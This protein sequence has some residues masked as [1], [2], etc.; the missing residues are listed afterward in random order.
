MRLS[1]LP[2]ARRPAAFGLARVRSIV[3]TPPR[4]GSSPDVAEPRGMRIPVGVT[5]HH[6]IL[7][8]CDG[9]MRHHVASPLWTRMPERWPLTIW[10]DARGILYPESPL[11]QP[12]S[13]G[14]VGPVAG[15]GEGGGQPAC[16]AARS[17]RRRCPGWA[18]GA[19]RRGRAP[20]VRSRGYA[21]ADQRAHS[22]PWPRRG[23]ARVPGIA[24]RSP[25]R[26]VW[27]RPCRQRA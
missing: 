14:L 26:R 1:E 11:C 16:A 25:R 6:S 15:V 27:Q 13:V 10:R 2:P 22:G 4:R 5:V 21:R 24:L 20:A 18:P 8:R 17:R 19:T 7:T 23:D 3:A 9:R 12:R